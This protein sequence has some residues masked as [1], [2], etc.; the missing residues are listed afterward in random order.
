MSNILVEEESSICGK[1]YKICFEDAPFCRAI[2]A[3]GTDKDGRWMTV[4]QIETDPEYRNKGECQRLLRDLKEGCD[5]NGVRFGLWCP[6]ND[7]IKHIT[8]KLKIKVY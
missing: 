3:K 8:E 5:K 7:V 6:M 2:V 1:V 4:Y